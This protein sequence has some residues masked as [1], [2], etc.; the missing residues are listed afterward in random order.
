MTG[1]DQ[2][3]LRL[4]R[5][6]V[7]LDASRESLEA[8]E[9]AARVAARLQAELTGLFVEDED[10]LNLAGLPFAREIAL[11]GDGGRTLNP[12]TVEKDLRQQA[13]QARRA[14]EDTAKRR[15]LRWSFRVTRGRA[16][17]ELVAAAGDADLV[18]VGKAV[19][20]LTRR[21]RLGTTAR[22]VTAGTTAAVLLAGG[23]EVLTHTG[24]VMTSYDGSG[25]A[26]RAL[27]L[28]VRMA[29]NDGGELSVFLLPG[30]RPPGVLQQ[31]VVAQS[32][33]QGLD[34]Q[35]RAVDPAHLPA[36]I[37]TEQGGLLVLGADCLPADTDALAGL[38]EAAN[39][40]VLLIRS[41]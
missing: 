31:E 32:A 22:A 1:T 37:H 20:P 3:G 26:K 34:L 14:L 2:H 6:L 15:S 28:A 5:I 29:H 25:C 13:A 9:A 10:L 23:P 41:G 18:A 11:T 17:S 19:R 35:F 36:A 30:G 24:R 16:G 7:G 40:P 27:A 39:C 12:E 38:V 8:L 4:R 33:E 21:A